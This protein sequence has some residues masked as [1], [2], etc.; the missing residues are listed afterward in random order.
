MR[1][2]HEDNK[3]PAALIGLAIVVAALAGAFFYEDLPLIGSGPRYTAEFAESAGLEVGDEVRIFGVRA[4]RVKAVELNG[5]KVMVAFT[6]GGTDLG[7]QTR[8]SIE[9][10]DLLGQ[11]FLAVEPAGGGELDP[12]TVIPL[13]RTRSPF[14]VTDAV[15]GLSTTVGEI[16]APRLAQS[17][18]VLSE[19]FADSPRDVRSALTGLT[20]LSRTISS[21]DAELRQLLGNTRTVSAVLA[22]RNHVFAR[23]LGDG[24]LLLDEL[25]RRREA[26]D[27]FLTATRQMSEQFSGLVADNQ[28]QIGPALAQLDRILT[29]LQRHRDDIELAVQRLAPTVRL[30]SNVIGSGRFFEAYFCNIIPP[31]AGPI[32]PE[33]CTP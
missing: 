5:D 20:R 9:I 13:S 11:K 10:K 23:L 2:V 7:D 28:R 22:D 12:D 15:S 30:G 31:S 26:I 25:R 17:M 19:T 18:E 27:G 4:G 29:I 1:L 24:N 3:I 32:N 21:R 33:G 14:D 8:A 16:D 6:V